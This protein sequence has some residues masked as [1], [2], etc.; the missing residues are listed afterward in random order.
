MFAAASALLGLCLLATPAEGGVRR[1]RSLCPPEPCLTVHCEPVDEQTCDGLVR[2]NSGECGCCDFCIKQLDAGQL[3][4]GTMLIG[5]APPKAECKEGLR[6][7]PDTA[8]CTE[9]HLIP[10]V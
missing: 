2:R 3:C 8:L 10:S 7:H 4:E 5:N 9:T 1:R 6:C